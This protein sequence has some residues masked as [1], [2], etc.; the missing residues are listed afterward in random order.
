MQT[1]FAA[2][3]P[4]GQFAQKR[5][6]MLGCMTCIAIVT[7]IIMLMSARLIC[8]KGTVRD[9]G[10]T[11]KRNWRGFKMLRADMRLYRLGHVHAAKQHREKQEGTQ[12]GDH[13]RRLCQ[14]RRPMQGPIRL[15]Y[16]PTHLLHTRR[17]ETHLL[18]A[19]QAPPLPSVRLAFLRFAPGGQSPLRALRDLFATPSD[20]GRSASALLGFALSRGGRSALRA[21]WAR[22][23]AR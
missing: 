1:R 16:T 15:S 18:V 3:R 5:A 8:V 22:A 17:C 7:C 19:P 10:G 9:R 11:G 21:L 23:I 12:G 20:A 2:H 13:G 14:H 4:L 6:V